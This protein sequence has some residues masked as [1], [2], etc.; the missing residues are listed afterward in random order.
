MALAERLTTAALR[1]CIQC[2]LCVES[3]PTFRETR[4][5]GLSP[6]GRIALLRDLCASESEPGKKA[7]NPPALVDAARAE[8]LDLCLLCGA[9]ERACPA[10]V[11][12]PELLVRARGQLAGAQAGGRRRRRLRRILFVFRR[13]RL[14]RSL[15][16]FVRRAAYS[17][18]GALAVRLFAAPEHRGH[19]LDLLASIRLPKEERG[20]WKRSPGHRR[21]KRA[22]EASEVTIALFHGC[23]TPVFFPRVLIELERRLANAGVRC[24]TPARQVCCGALHAHHGDL[25][26]ARDLARRNILAFERTGEARIL[27]ESAACA[28]MLKS[29][30]GLLAGDPSF[31]ERAAEFSARV[32]EAADFSDSPE[33]CAGRAAVAPAGETGAGP[34]AAREGGVIQEPCRGSCR[35]GGPCAE[36]PL[37][38]APLEP[39][40]CGAGG[41]YLLLEPAMSSRLGERRAEE[42]AAALSGRASGAR[43]VCVSDPGCRL[44]LAGRLRRRGIAVRHALEIEGRIASRTMETESPRI[45]LASAA[46]R[47]GEDG[48]QVGEGGGPA[49]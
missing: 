47:R 7:N 29:Y 2:G 23:V 39:S 44:Q 48:S 41:L 25:A 32:R 33:A 37:E 38:E 13:P 45:A 35:S 30:G 12:V 40:C 34:G 26:S 11:A 16:V 31:A 27:A 14:T 18:L 22:R 9:C 1:A 3:C 8:A 49:A 19:F 43:T 17:G 15:L 24:E 20:R 46:E 36:G 21:G 10:G 42:L 5:E 6:R 28:T 4:E